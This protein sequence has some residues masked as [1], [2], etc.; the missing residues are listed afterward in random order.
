LW[1]LAVLTFFLAVE[2]PKPARAWPRWGW[3][4]AFGMI[5]GMAMGTKLTGWLIP[6]PLL[7]WCA[8]Y[9][10]PFGLLALVVGGLVGLMT[11]VAL[12]PPFWVDPFTGIS[13]FFRSNLTRAQTI[14]IRTL[15]L[16]RVY[17]TPIDSLPWY[18]T[19]VWT[20]LVTP[21]GFLGLAIAGAWRALRRFSGDGFGVLV[22]LNAGFL[23]VLRALPHAP[24]HDG[25]R[26]FLPAFGLLAVTAGLGAGWVASRFWGRVFVGLSIVEAA[27]S[28]AV[29]MPVPLA[30]YT[31]L[32]GGL[33]GATA[34]GMEPTFYW[35]GLTDNALWALDKKTRSGE[36]VL[37]SGYPISWY[38]RHTGRLRAGLSP[39]DGPDFA[40]YVVQNRPGSMSDTDRALV[41]RLGADPRYVLSAKL[42]VPLVWAFPGDAPELASTHSAV[43]RLWNSTLLTRP[44]G[45]RP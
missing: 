35:D 12:T 26:Q 22:L 27:V 41:A 24:G 20:V 40:W 4:L 7:V 25:V 42:G 44:G 37:F 32:V 18:N 2:E 3:V 30:Y 28:V 14:P 16:G 9:R 21:V 11:V 38:N 13:R 34:L 36:N 15:F 1:L 39:I 19:L 10:R 17:R 23:L 8:L 5:L 31:P 43:R 6:L 33:P 45:D 29:M